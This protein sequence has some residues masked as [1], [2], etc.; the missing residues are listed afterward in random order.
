MGGLTSEHRSEK[1]HK[2]ERANPTPCHVIEDRNFDPRNS[3]TIPS[4]VSRRTSTSEPYDD[5]R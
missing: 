2:E 4:R 1:L 3:R 5:L